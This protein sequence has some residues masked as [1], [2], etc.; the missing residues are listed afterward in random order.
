M[1]YRVDPHRDHTGQVTGDWAI[2]DKRL[3]DN[4]KVMSLP[5]FC[6]LD[7]E[8]LRFRQLSHAYAW[9]E[10]CRERG[11]DLGT[12]GIKISVYKTGTAGRLLK[13]SEKYSR[14]DRPL[15]PGEH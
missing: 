12:D 7:G 3:S 15:H 6:A 10:L 2:W 8:V 11:L 4:L 14:G 13:V 1:R 5:P 9:L